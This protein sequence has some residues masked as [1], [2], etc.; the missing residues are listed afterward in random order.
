MSCYAMVHSKTR[1]PRVI[2]HL[3]D[4]LQREEYCETAKFALGTIEI[5]NYCLREVHFDLVE[6][7]ISNFKVE[8]GCPLKHSTNIRN[9]FQILDRNQALFRKCQKAIIAL[10]V[11]ERRKE[12]LSY[13]HVL[14]IITL[15]TWETRGT[16]FWTIPQEISK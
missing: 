10:L 8:P 11:L 7:P 14:R 4:T 5:D 16:R 9:Y 15:M 2:W 12:F 13:R 1:A 3:T 6:S